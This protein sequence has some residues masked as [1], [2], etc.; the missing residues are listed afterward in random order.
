MQ[1]NV[2][3]Q[4][5]RVEDVVHVRSGQGKHV[6]AATDVLR[7]ST[8]EGIGMLHPREDFNVVRAA[9]DLFDPDNKGH[10]EAKDLYRACNRLGFAVSERDI[11]NMLSVLAPSEPVNVGPD[12]VA[13]KARAIS[14]DKFAKMMESSY[15]RRYSV[16][17]CIF[18][19]VCAVRNPLRYAV[20]VSAHEVFVR[21]AFSDWSTH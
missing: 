20:Y 9:Y 10:I 4:L 7:R 18:R 19:Q 14:Y 16:G 8:T 1:E 2:R 12:T 15:R 11:D 6:G 3:D 21:H 17:D 13:V 5:R